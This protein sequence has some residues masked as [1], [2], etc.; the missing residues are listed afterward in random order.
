MN[1]DW[2]SMDVTCD[3]DYCKSNP[4]P[5][6][7][8]FFFFIIMQQRA[9]FVCPSFSVAVIEYNN[10][11]CTGGPLFSQSRHRV[12]ITN[13][14]ARSARTCAKKF[15]HP[16][17]QETLTPPAAVQCHGVSGNIPSQFAQRFFFFFR[18]EN[19]TKV[20]PGFLVKSTSVM[21]CCHTGYTRGKGL[22]NS[23]DLTH[24]RAV[25][26]TGCVEKCQRVDFLN[27]I[28]PF[29]LCWCFRLRPAGPRD[30]FPEKETYLLFG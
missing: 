26:P 12:T 30:I 21:K 29:P 14:L 23:L 3:C 4:T 9:H 27:P 6:L 24:T 28:V 16:R 20:R 5:P 15:P 8:P 11:S 2:G 7:H 22:L 25:W 17:H 19:L 10:E 18:C 1:C 13:R